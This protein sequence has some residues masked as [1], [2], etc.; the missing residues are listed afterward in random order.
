MKMKLIK[1]ANA[2]VVPLLLLVF[3]SQTSMA[4]TVPVGKQGYRVTVAKNWPMNPEGARP[5][6]FEISRKPRKA[7][8]RDEVFTVTLE[9][10]AYLGGRELTDRFSRQVTIPAGA[11][12]VES[13]ILVNSNSNY[14]YGDMVLSIESG[15]G[16]GQF[17]ASDL[18]QTS[19]QSNMNPNGYITS[20]VLHLGDEFKGG[21]LEDSSEFWRG[22]PSSQR[23]AYGY[24]Y[25]RAVAA[26]PTFNANNTTKVLGLEE[27]VLIGTSNWLKSDF[28]CLPE[29]WRGLS[30]IEMIVIDIADL[31][32]LCKEESRRVMLEKWVAAG[33]F[34]VVGNPRNDFTHVEQI[35]PTLLGNNRPASQWEVFGIDQALEKQRIQAQKAA[36]AKRL[37]Q[38]FEV[39]GPSD[40]EY[41]EL[42]RVNTQEP[43]TLAEIEELSG[44]GA[45]LS[46]Y[47]SGAVAAVKDVYDKENKFGYERLTMAFAQ[48]RT[49]SIT[50]PQLAYANEQ[51]TMSPIPDVGNPPVGLFGTLIFGFL[52]LIGP[53]II[54]MIR[55]AKGK[56]QHLFFMVPLFSFL[57]CVAILGYSVITNLGTQ[58]GRAETLTVVHPVS[59]LALTHTATAYYCGDQPDSYQYDSETLVGVELF[60]GDSSRFLFT[61]DA[62][63]VAGSRISPRRVHIMTTEKVQPVSIGLRLTKTPNSEAPTVVNQLGSR[64]QVAAVKFNDKFY[65]VS[66]IEDGASKVAEPFDQDEFCIQSRKHLKSFNPTETIFGR[67]RSEVL[68]SSPSIQFSQD[69]IRGFNRRLESR[70]K[71]N[72]EY[73]AAV[74]NDLLTEDLIEPFNYKIKNHIIY[75]KY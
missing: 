43:I 3:A 68:F 48:L 61:D 6:R 56:K 14:M 15:S 37:A 4:Q 57:T 23:Y 65:M 13:E 74:D 2:I 55:R 62:V 30:S 72:G 71:H 27:T 16:N 47:L 29:D 49:F 36:E 21:L 34:L 39:D 51:A 17:D 63:R 35:F 46:T 22:M 69:F 64:V 50:K 26:T 8:L 58:W 53:V 42:F 70:L 45:V 75:G 20:F 44:D 73:L 66:D 28:S 54:F 5:F 32:K 19:V 25:A 18:Y 60:G 1:C 12:S 40:E 67:S 31:Q 10:R 33:G 52:L 9:S 24:S 59:G 41:E 11:I 7:S 38:G